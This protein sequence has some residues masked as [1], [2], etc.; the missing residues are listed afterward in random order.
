MSGAGRHRARRPRGSSG[1]AAQ[2]GQP[3]GLAGARSSAFTE[4][5]W[6]CPAA[7]GA[8]TVLSG[9]KSRTP[10]EKRPGVSEVRCMHG[11]KRTCRGL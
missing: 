7:L 8:F 11:G 1:A 6:G 5:F 2:P 4:P 10:S 3:L 9:A